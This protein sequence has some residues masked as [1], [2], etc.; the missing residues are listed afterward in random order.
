[1]SV[2]QATIQQADPTAQWLYRAGGISALLLGLAYIIIIALYVP[3]GAPPSAVEAQLVYLAGN[4]AAWWAILGLSVLTD[5]L[6]V[7]VA[8]ALYFALKGINRHVMLVAST[9]VGLFVM[10]DL[11]ITWTNYAALI[12]LSDSYAAAA[13][14]AQRALVFA[15]AMPASIVLKSTLLFVY[16]TLILA[17]G[18]FMAGLVM[19]NGVFSKYTAYLGIATGVL[20]GV[21]VVGP[22]LTSALSATII[23]TSLLTTVWVLLVGLRLLKLGRRS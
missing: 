20:G 5:F 2:Q 10:L 13:S 6:F 1:M 9:C 17:V 22:L 19:L 23:I 3:M 4:T 15:A 14:D 7:P 8:F 12:T 16:N 11:A 21:S 18:I